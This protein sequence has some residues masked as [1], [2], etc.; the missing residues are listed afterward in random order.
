MLDAA[1]RVMVLSAKCDLPHQ[2]QGATAMSYLT[3]LKALN[4]KKHLPDE[5]TKLTKAPP[6][7]FVS[8]L[9]K[10]RTET[11]KS[12]SVSFVS[13][14]GRA[15]SQNIADW[16]ERAAIVE[17]EAG[18]PGPWVQVSIHYWPPQR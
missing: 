11:D 9:D 3:R 4:E 2:S 14:Q 16:E 12:P 13:D 15:V 18:L 6:E 10:V 1:A 17:Y 8:D 7:P 5:L